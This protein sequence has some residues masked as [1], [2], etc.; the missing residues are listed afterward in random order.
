MPQSLYFKYRSL[1]NWKFIVDIFVNSRL[2]AAQ[3]KTL[4]D[5]MEGRY[6]YKGDELSRAFRKM[7]R[8]QKDELRICSLSRDPLNT[9]MWS[10]YAGGH[11]GIVLGF[12]IRSPRSRLI[13]DVRYDSKM[14]IGPQHANLPPFE[15]AQEILSQKQQNWIHEKEVRV[16]SRE[17]F[18]PIE[19]KEVR[20]GCKASSED[21]ELLKALLDKTNQGTKLIRVTRSQLDAPVETFDSPV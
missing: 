2:Y 8:E 4:N 11:T 12:K 10:Y 13:K 7:V 5:P 17:T 19:L 14:K 21:E 15:L 18:V 9:L 3:F 1:D 16:F 20:L 6:Y